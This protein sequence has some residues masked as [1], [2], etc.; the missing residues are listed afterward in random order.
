MPKI[1]RR[2][3]LKTVWVAVVF[4]GITVVSFWVI[5]L[6]PGSPTDL[7]TTMNPQVTPEARAR[8]EK[9]YGL[10]QPVHVQY[11]RW[12]ARL[13]TFDFGQ[14]V[15]GDN[16]PVWD[17]IEERLPLTF[18]MNVASLALTLLLAVPIGVLSAW[19]QNGPFD[20]AMTVLVFIGFAMPGFWLA[21]LLMLWLGIA[22]PVLPISGITSLD[23]PRLS[24][25]GQSLDLLRHLALPIFIYTFGSLAGLSRFMRASMLEVLRQDYIMTAR[26]KGLP[27]RAVIFR[28][29]LRNALMPVITILG[30]SVPG[31]IGGSVIIESI[32]ALPGLGQLFYQAVM[33]RDYPLIMGSLVLGAVLT[34]AGNLL[35]DVGYGLADPRVRQGPGEAA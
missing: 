9:L 25:W 11:A 6:A 4:L 18:G 2:L 22:W 14:S 34:L 30:L 13:A 10:D 19:K 24:F 29:A 35:A 27:E 12:L 26:A 8:L 15:S 16:R 7:Q 28:H 20:R 17:K 23:F 33:S 32:F 5:H 1:L 31:L 21:L 3:L